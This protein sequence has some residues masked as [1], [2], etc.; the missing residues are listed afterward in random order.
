MDGGAPECGVPINA[1]IKLRFDRF[2]KPSTATRQ[3]LRVYSGDPDT[4]LCQTTGGGETGCFFQPSYDL[5]ERVL[6]YRLAENT[7]FVP[8]LLYTVEV[9]GPGDAGTDGLRAFDGAPLSEEGSAPLKFQ[10]RTSTMTGDELPVERATCEQAMQIFARCSTPGCHAT[11]TS[12]DPCPEGQASFQGSC[13]G[14]PR[15]GMELTSPEAF[16]RTVR[17]QVAH[18]TELGGTAGTPLENPSR[19]GVSMPRIDPGQPG[20][21]YLLYKLLRDPDAF[22]SDEECRSIYGDLAE[23]E[24]VRPSAEERLRLRLWFV[25]GEPMPLR[26]PNA[27]TLPLQMTQLRTI[28][29]F[30]AGGANCL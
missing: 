23:G 19:L 10:F 14:V 13:V 1:I 4:S 20:N 30:I 3:S 27:N 11:R 29:S 22:G 6:I 24:C 8:N 15:M 9:L 2:L 17:G 25:L 18:Q 28:Q 5:I 21:S 7:T 16:L 12:D 26:G